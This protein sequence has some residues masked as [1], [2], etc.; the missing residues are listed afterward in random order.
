[1]KPVAIVIPWFGVELTG[2]AEQQAFQIATR[3]AARGN[4]VEVL[5]TCG[6][7]FDSD[8][9]VNYFD[10]GVYKEA[11]V[12]VRRFPVDAR[13][14]TAFDQVN[15]KLLNLD[16]DELLPGTQPISDEDA[17]TFLFENIKSAALL[18]YLKAQAQRYQAFIFLPYMFQTTMLGALSVRNRSWLQPCLH[19]EPQAY[20]SETEELFRSVRGLLFNSEGELELALKLYGPGII[21]RSVVIGEGVERPTYSAEDIQRALPEFLRGRRF[22]LYVG[23]RD[24]TKNLDLLIRSFIDFRSRNRDSKLLLVLAG[25]GNEAFDSTHGIHDVGLVSHETRVALLMAARALVQPS[26]NESFSRTMMEAWTLGRP[27]AV[28]S[29]C[30]ATAMAV[31]I[32]GGG[33]TAANQ[34]EWSALFQLIDVVSQAELDQRGSKGRRY[35]SEHADWEKVIP[36]YESILGLSE[37][38]DDGLA[39]SEIHSLRAYLPAIHQLLPDIVFGDAISNEACAIRDLL[40]Q[41]GFESEI[42][43]ERRDARMAQSAKLFDEFKPGSDDGLF[44][45]HSIGSEITSFARVHQGP[46]CLIYHNITPAEYFSPF[47]PGFAWLLE[48]GRAT[49]GSLAQYFPTS[50]GDSAFNAAALAAYGFQNPGVL[51]IIIDP[52]KWNIAPDEPLMKRLQDGRRNLIFVGRIAPNK[53]Q[54][55]LVEAFSHYRKLDPDSRL[56]LVGEGRLSDPFLHHLREIIRRLDLDAHVE[57]TGLVD[58]SALLAYYRT[59]HLYWSFSEHEGFAAPVVESMWFDVPVLALNAGAVPETISSDAALFEVDDPMSDVA[60]RAHQLVN[61]PG[62]RQVFIDTQRRRRTDFTRESVWPILASLIERLAQ[63]SRSTVTV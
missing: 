32:S 24:R 3:L 1:M 29:R 10:A 40:R 20:F 44:Y 25:P 6:R 15:A 9:A 36:R 35:A 22:V 13:D 62:I 50:V 17:R 37:A 34:P 19:N 33:W 53:K 42:F 47:R 28:N 46:K 18:D 52:D 39:A 41:E 4:E 43:A 49:L 58:D 31:R 21:Q 63:A 61:D 55:R 8:W 11:N 5:T 38:G 56:I 45:H 23:R 51:P 60:L 27:V 54:D 30:E 16:A 14:S 2:G 59:A 7:S 26:Q 48:E 57:F 12:T